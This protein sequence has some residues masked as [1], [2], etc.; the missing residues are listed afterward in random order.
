MMSTFRLWQITYTQYTMSTITNDERVYHPYTFCK[1][2]DIEH[3]LRI[4][5]ECYGHPTIHIK[6]HELAG[7][8]ALL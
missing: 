5:V 7:V 8:V 4:R 3:L 2:L 1:S 6:K